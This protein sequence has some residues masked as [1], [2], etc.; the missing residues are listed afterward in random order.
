MDNIR[1]ASQEDGVTT[2]YIVD[3]NRPYAQVLEEY[4]DGQLAVRYVYALDLISQERNGEEL[5]YQVDGL[6]STRVLTDADGVARNSYTYDA[7]GELIESNG[8]SENDYLFAGEQY[9]KEL[10]QYY[11]RERYY[12]AGIGR[13]TRRDTYEGSIFD[14]IT[15]HKYLYGNADPVNGIDPSGL[16]TLQEAILSI[17]ILGILFLLPA[18]TPASYY[19]SEPVTSYERNNR[20]QA[21]SSLDFISFAASKGYLE[22]YY[23]IAD[24]PSHR[25]RYVK[26]PVDSERAIDM[27]HLLVVTNFFPGYDLLVE[28]WQGVVER[29]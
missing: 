4:V 6:G 21:V 19:C 15:L 1:V 16:L 20:E 26:D 7:F 28:T 25:Y 14:P 17:E 10:G 18:D 5:V 12:D 11:L 22:T 27:F 3:R 2:R 29:G 9:D 8:T 13:F 24:N 23:Q